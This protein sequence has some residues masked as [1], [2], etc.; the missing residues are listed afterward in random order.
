MSRARTSKLDTSVKFCVACA[1]IATEDER[2][3]NCGAAIPR[4]T[5]YQ[6][7]PGAVICWECCEK[8]EGD[9]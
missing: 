6:A 8:A 1:R 2:C 7:Y 5:P 4:G 3:D 9:A